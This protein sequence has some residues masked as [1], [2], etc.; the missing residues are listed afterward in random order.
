MS[1]LGPDVIDI[2]D[3]F[4]QTAVEKQSLPTVKEKFMNYFT[5]TTRTIFQRFLFNNIKTRKR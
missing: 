4:E 1:A 2:F 3:R 5:P